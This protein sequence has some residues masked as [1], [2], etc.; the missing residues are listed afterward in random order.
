M[1]REPLV[2]VIIPSYDS[3]RTLEL[4]LRSVAEQTHAP[5]EILVVDDCSTDG[6]AHIAESMGVTVLRTP[7]NSGQSVARNLGAEH[8]RGSILFF[9]DADVALA[10]DSVQAA[11]AALAA[12]A[13]LGAVSGVYDLEP[14]LSTSL[15]AQYR[16][17]QMHHWWMSSEGPTGGPHTAMFA[18]WASVFREIGSFNPR[19]RHTE[20]QEYGHRLRQRYQTRMSMSVHG[21]HGHEA[22]LRVLL[23][24]V[25][26]RARA[27]MLEWRRGEALGGT[28]GAPSRAVSSGLLLG[29]LLAL[30]LPSWFGI[31]GAGVTPALLAIAIALDTTTY[32]R[33]FADRGVL[34]G[35]YFVAV[36]LV[37]QLTAALGAL[38]GAAQRTVRAAAPGWA[39]G[40]AR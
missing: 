23:P 36:H 22:S 17:R 1:T 34:F 8:A 2:S 12:D 15:L 3:A 19:L 29:A 25:F 10:P 20:P 14:L 31:A 33:V 35:L 26:R 27:S 7:V 13:S 28:H 4:C 24:K 40:E 32:R 39:A 37:F 18:I 16:A 38:A 21:R 6:S 30:P 5:I 11:V 9:L